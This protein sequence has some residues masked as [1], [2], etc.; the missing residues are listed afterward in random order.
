MNDLKK[1]EEKT[2]IEWQSY[3]KNPEPLFGGNYGWICPKCGRVYSPL[4]H[5]CPYCVENNNSIDNGVT[6]RTTNKI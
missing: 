4:T 3:A 6:Y 2:N 5:M 1:D